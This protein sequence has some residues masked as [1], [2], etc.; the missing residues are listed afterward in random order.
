MY[1]FNIEFKY[2][3]GFVLSLIVSAV[4]PLCKHN[5]NPQYINKCEFYFL[6][7][8]N[9]TDISLIRKLNIDFLLETLP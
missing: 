8:F 2:E 4:D 6:S 9:S 5:L 7:L 1:F 3:I